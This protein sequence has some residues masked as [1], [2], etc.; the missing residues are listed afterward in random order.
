MIVKLCKINKKEYVILRF[1]GHKKIKR[2]LKF[3]N[4]YAIYIIFVLA[5]LAVSA[6]I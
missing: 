6:I 5:V 1:L 4:M 3:S 2:L